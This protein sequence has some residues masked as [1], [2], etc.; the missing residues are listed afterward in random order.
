MEFFLFG[1]IWFWIASAVIII[2][3]I[4]SVCKDS[5]V[6]STVFSIGGLLFLQYVAKIDIIGYVNH[7][8]LIS[9]G[10]VGGYVVIGVV[11]MIIKW[12]LLLKSISYAYSTIR[13]EWYEGAKLMPMF[14]GQT[15]EQVM[16]SFAKEGVAHAQRLSAKYGVKRVP[17]RVRD[18]YPT[19]FFWAFYWPVSVAIT[20]LHDSVRKL[21]RFIITRLS[22]MMQIMS[23]KEFNKYQE[24]YK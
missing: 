16:L 4:T 1:T 15:K 8:P 19:L 10:I 13:E 14:S 20:L 23:D 2:G 24:L 11:W 12:Q 21:F 5:G 18:E 6:M 7:H 22:G 9:A 3:L 17:L